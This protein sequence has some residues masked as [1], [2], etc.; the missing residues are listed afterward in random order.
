MQ[1]FMGCFLTEW[2]E[3][4]ENRLLSR[5]A[6][7]EG[8]LFRGSLIWIVSAVRRSA[9][10]PTEN[11]PAIPLWILPPRY[12]ARCLPRHWG[13]CRQPRQAPAG[14]QRDV[15]DFY[16][17]CKT[18]PFKTKKGPCIHQEND[19]HRAPVIFIRSANVFLLRTPKSPGS[20]TDQDQQTGASNFVNID[21]AEL[22]HIFLSTW[23]SMEYLIQNA[24]NL[25]F[26][27]PLLPDQSIW[28]LCL[29]TKNSGSKSPETVDAPEF[30]Q[31]HLYRLVI[32]VRKRDTEV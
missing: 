16:F 14:E 13:S 24:E 31:A 12:P 4:C 20:L 30:S 11:P 17:S 8:C 22:C 2:F 21:F 18:T 29:P 1:R 28:H 5:A 3:P 23:H 6:L 9:L 10:L 26:K 27:S 7:N 19:R 15:Y 32:L 25:R